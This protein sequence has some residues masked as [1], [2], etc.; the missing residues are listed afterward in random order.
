MRPYIGTEK[1]LKNEIFLENAVMFLAGAVSQ[2]L[3]ADTTLVPGLP[4]FPGTPMK[5]EPTSSHSKLEGCLRV[6]RTLD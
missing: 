1:Y 5:H 6:F 4:T 2:E 3:F